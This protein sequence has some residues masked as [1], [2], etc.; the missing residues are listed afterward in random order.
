VE[1]GTASA[2]P[3]PLFRSLPMTK[4]GDVTLSG[5]ERAETCGAVVS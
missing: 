2:A 3:M 4:K 5:Y 1:K